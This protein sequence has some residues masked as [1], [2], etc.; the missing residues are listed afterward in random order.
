MEKVDY[1]LMKTVI[2]VFGLE[3]KVME[4]GARVIGVQGELGIRELFGEKNNKEDYLGLDYMDGPGVDMVTNVQSIPLPDNSVKSIVAM[5]LFEHVEKFWLVF[6]EMKRIIDEDG[7]IVC[8][9]PFSYNIHA[10]P[11]DYFRFTPY[12]YESQFKTFKYRLHVSIGSSL[13]PKMV[14]VIASNRPIIEERLE[15]FKEL[16]TRRYRQLI[17]SY[18][19]WVFYLR[20]LLCG[21]HFKDAIRNFG[22]I[23]INL[24]T[25]E[26]FPEGWV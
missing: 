3:S 1:Q 5:N 9:T 11:Y 25:D 4:L 2:E 17:P 6:D 15:L 10:C 19:R 7:T 22:E 12:F 21:N 14:Y 13:R 8:A 18:K 20:S 16:M 23:N 24:V 26:N